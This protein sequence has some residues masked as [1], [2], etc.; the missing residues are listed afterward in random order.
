MV[1]LVDNVEVE[2]E[3]VERYLAVVRDLAV[4]VMTGAGASLVSC[5][6]TAEEDGEPVCIQIVWGFEGYEQWNVIRRNL[7]LDPRWYEYASRTAALR[8]G[9]RRRFYTPADF[10]PT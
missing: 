4:P 5:A 8:T 6:T 1:H 9:G 2:P 10:S 3:C 7:V